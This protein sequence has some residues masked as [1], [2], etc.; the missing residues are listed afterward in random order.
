MI[1]VGSDDGLDDGQFPHMLDLRQT[2]VVTVG[3][4]VVVT[5][6]ADIRIVVAML[7][8]RIRLR[9]RPLGAPVTGLSAAYTTTR[10]FG[11]A[12]WCGRWVRGRRFGGV[13][14]VLIELRFELSQLGA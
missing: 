3:T 8:D 2:S 5:V 6:W 1:V 7:I 9:Y 12:R 13:L 14:R 4:Q 11:R 10:R